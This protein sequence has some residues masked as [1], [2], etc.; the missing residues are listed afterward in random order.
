MEQVA[1]ESP[2]SKVFFDHVHI[3]LSDLVLVFAGQWQ[4]LRVLDGISFICLRSFARLYCLLAYVEGFSR[5]EISVKRFYRVSYRGSR[6]PIALFFAL[7]YGHLNN[8]DPPPAIQRQ[9]N[10]CKP[11]QR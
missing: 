6:P 1:D 8:A 10:R 7:I 3:F 11:R 5:V 2:H 4:D 9:V